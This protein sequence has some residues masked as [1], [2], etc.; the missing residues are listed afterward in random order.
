MLR[1]LKI[2]LCL[3]LSL[4]LPAAGTAGCARAAAGQSVT[5]LDLFDTVTTVKA[6]NI[7]GERFAADAERL[8][9]FLTGLHRLC[10]I[11]TTYPDVPNLAALNAAA[12][13]EALALDRQLLELLSFGLEVCAQT[14]GRVNIVSG[15]LLAPWH[16]ARTAAAEDPAR[17]ALPDAATLAAAARHIDPTSLVVDLTAGTAQLTDP[18]ARVDVGALAK[19]FA[20]ERA[21][22]FVTE[23]LGWT[24]ALLDLGGNVRTVGGKPGGAP[25]V[26]GVQDPDGEGYLLTVGVHD[27]AVVTSGDYQRFF[28]VGGR[29]YAHI[30]DPATRYPAA[31]MRA[32]TV[33]CPDSAM[34][35][36]LSTALFL[37]TP[38]DGANWVEQ[39]SGVEAVWIKNDGTLAYSSGFSAYLT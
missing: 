12:G 39:L 5:W 18:L 37:L 8:H 3:L 17:A 10:D 6:Y 13:G 16:D 25:F 19:G 24:N 15:A 34:A 38:E 28:T 22:E 23:E 11:Y 2:G 7:D 21:A 27:A 26:I 33:I 31:F 29:R 36:A 14:D 1:R 9:T 35:D 30:I 32:V 20:A 4:L